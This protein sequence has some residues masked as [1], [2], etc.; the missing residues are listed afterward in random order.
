MQCNVY[1]MYNNNNNGVIFVEHRNI[2]IHIREHIYTYYL[3]EM[4]CSS[5]YYHHHH[6]IYANNSNKHSKF[7]SRQRNPFSSSLASFPRHDPPT[8]HIVRL[9]LITLYP[10]ILFIK[11]KYLC[12]IPCQNIKLIHPCALFHA[13]KRTRSNIFFLYFHW[14]L[15]HTST[16]STYIYNQSAGNNNNDSTST[17]IYISVISTLSLEGGHPVE[18]H[19]QPE[20]STGPLRRVYKLLSHLL[21][22][23]F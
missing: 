14:V 8:P 5:V 3:H 11:Q 4:A 7:S 18:R 20:S 2:Y 22:L 12:I 19:H 13:Y 10:Y 17:Y 9:T 1:T 21:F 15:A 16:C 6:G 23:D